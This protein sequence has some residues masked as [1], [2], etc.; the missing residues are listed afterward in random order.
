MGLGEL[1]CL[2]LSGEPKI[3]Q[4]ECKKEASTFDFCWKDLNKCFSKSW[5][6]KSLQAASAGREHLWDLKSTE[7]IALIPGELQPC[8]PKYPSSLN[9]TPGY[10]KKNSG[11]HFCK[12]PATVAHG[13]GMWKQEE[14]KAEQQGKSLLYPNIIPELKLCM[15]WGTKATDK[16]LPAPVT[17]SKL[18]GLGVMALTTATS[19][20]QNFHFQPWDAIGADSISKLTGLVDFLNCKLKSCINVVPYLPW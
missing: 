5:F 2:F 6:S 16:P 11:L 8:S 3:L 19:V 4:Q 13:K 17:C 9:R 15:C 1:I 20:G 18:K 12:M 7:V 14:R 10:W